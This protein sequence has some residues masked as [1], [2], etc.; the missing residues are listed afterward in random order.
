MLAHRSPIT[1]GTAYDYRRHG[2]SNW[3]AAIR[4]WDDEALIKCADY[5]ARRSS[6]SRHS[7]AIADAEDNHWRLEREWLRRHG[8]T[9]R[10][11]SDAILCVTFCGGDDIV[12]LTPPLE[13]TE[14]R[15]YEPERAG[16]PGFL[17]KIFLDN[18]TD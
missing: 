5:Y 12:D 7:M 2:W 4:T 1:P 15:E 9:R 3:L 14:P 6:K 17:S 13:P 16:P 8:A 10:F 11:A 18:P